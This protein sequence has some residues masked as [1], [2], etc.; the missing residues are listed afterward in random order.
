MT[1]MHRLWPRPRTCLLVLRLDTSVCLQPLQSTTQ[2]VPVSNELPQ[3]RSSAQSPSRPCACCCVAIEWRTSRDKGPG[4]KRQSSCRD[5]SRQNLDRDW[6]VYYRLT[7]SGR[8][9]LGI[10][11]GSQACF[12]PGQ[13]P[14]FMAQLL[15]WSVPLGLDRPDSL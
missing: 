13:N 2:L 9:V 1:P 3:L 12:R 8:K 11:Y 6:W 4:R 14:G 5:E 7:A 10:L 15:T